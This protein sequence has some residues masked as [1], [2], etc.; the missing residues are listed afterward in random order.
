M[1]L[2]LIQRAIVAAIIMVASIA[3]AGTTTT[4]SNAA[5]PAS[6]ATIVLN[7]SFIGNSWRKQMEAEFTQVASA[8]QK[9][10]MIGSYSVVNGDNTVS[11]QIAELDSLIL[12]HV[13]A[14]CL[15]AA[16]ET[17]LNG[18]IAK[19]HQA[20]ILVVSFDGT[21]TS[22]RIV[23]VC[24]SSTWKFVPLVYFQKSARWNASSNC[25]VPTFWPFDV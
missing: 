5:S 14:I 25:V 22:K 4:R 23:P 9:Q 19:A 18:V 12:K 10:G 20:G 17:A 3:F 6:A 11:Q 21:V 2:S 15:D 7:N 24:F 16:S 1:K 8:A 13:S